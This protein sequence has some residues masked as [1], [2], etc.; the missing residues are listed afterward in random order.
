MDNF[1]NILKGIKENDVMVQS[2]CE[3]LLDKYSKT[4]VNQTHLSRTLQ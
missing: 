1:N 2:A 3:T 4:S